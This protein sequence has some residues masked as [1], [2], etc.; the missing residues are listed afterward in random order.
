MNIKNLLLAA[1]SLSTLVACQDLSGDPVLDK[2]EDCFSYVRDDQTGESYIDTTATYQ[3]ETYD[4]NTTF[5]MAIKNL[6]LTEGGTLKSARVSGMV[7]S[8]NGEMTDDDFYLYIAQSTINPCEGDMEVTSLAYYYYPGN[9]CLTFKVDGRYSVNVI[10]TY[11]TLLSRT[12]TVRNL[13]TGQDWVDESLNVPYH[14]N[15][16]PTESTVDIVAVG[17]KFADGMPSLEMTYPN[18]PVKFNSTGYTIDVDEFVP[19]VK[20]VAYP[21]FTITKFHAEVSLLP[22]GEKKFTYYV[23]DRGYV[24]T[25]LRAK[26]MYSATSSS[27]TSI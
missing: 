2:Y 19:T 18:L 20:G 10:P 15:F 25:V 1:C 6:A 21:A 13:T 16:N 12:T 26:D 4:Y 5:Q 3:L 27:I 9:T 17:P 7:H 22:N 11:Y 24:T 14:M 8:Q 23:K